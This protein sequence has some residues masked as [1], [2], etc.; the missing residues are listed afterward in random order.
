MY[1]HVLFLSIY[2]DPHIFALQFIW[3]PYSNP[4]IVGCIPNI[5][6]QCRTFW[7]A[8]VPLIH[9]GIV[10]FQCDDRVFQQFNFHQ[11]I[12]RPPP[13]SQHIHSV[14][15]GRFDENW[16]VKQ[17]YFISM[18]EERYTRWV[19]NLSPIEANDFQFNTEYYS[20]FLANGKP[21]LAS[22]EAVNK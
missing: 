5:V 1:F 6:L 3:Q 19:E 16:V 9:F 10:E 17:A 11:Q 8:C 18:W 22:V 13:A 21:F 14:H 20:W 2:R 7:G 12:L 15:R 4:A